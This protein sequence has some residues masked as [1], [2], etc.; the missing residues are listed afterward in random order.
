[1]KVSQF[2]RGYVAAL[3]SIGRVS[4]ALHSSNVVDTTE[5]PLS[6]LSVP[7]REFVRPR[8]PGAGALRIRHVASRFLVG[9]LLAS[10]LSPARC[11]TARNHS[12]H[13]DNH[14]KARF[15]AVRNVG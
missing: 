10:A 2:A 12:T 4:F 11:R 5:A 9:K 13:C 3:R 8:E 14:T 6:L 15:N 7:R 1:M